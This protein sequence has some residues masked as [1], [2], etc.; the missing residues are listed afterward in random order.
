MPDQKG[1]RSLL[2]C[3]QHLHSS[4]ILPSRVTWWPF[5]VQELQQRILELEN[6]LF[7]V[8]EISHNQPIACLGDGA[9][10]FRRMRQQEMSKPHV[11]QESDMKSDGLGGDWIIGNTR[12]PTL[13]GRAMRDVAVQAHCFT[14]SFVDLHLRDHVHVQTDAMTT[15]DRSSSPLCTTPPS[16][17]ADDG[18]PGSLLWIAVLSRHFSELIHVVERAQSTRVC[19][20]YED[21]LGTWVSLMLIVL[22]M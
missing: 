22:V 3:D 9:T 4:I 8:P 17:V 5:Q 11:A 19:F 1:M 12:H 6:R 10:F 16:K 20:L 21:V 2:V 15:H 18:K 13:K 7:S 14:P